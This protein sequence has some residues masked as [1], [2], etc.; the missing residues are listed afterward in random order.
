MANLFDQNM[1]PEIDA[2][3]QRIA[4]QQAIAEAM[5]TRSMAPL[6]TN[7]GP[8]HWTQALAQ[9]MN[10]RQGR[11][12]ID[13]A[14]RDRAGLGK[15]YQEG[16]ADEVKRIAALRQG[17]P[18]TETIVDEQANGGEGAPATITAPAVPNNRAAVEAAMLS[19]Y[20]P[21]RQMGM[22][23][24]SHLKKAD[25][26]YTLKPGE[27]RYGADGKLQNYEL[28]KESPEKSFK[29]GDIRK[30]LD[31]GSEVTQEFQKDGTW[32]E[33]SRGSRKE[34][35]SSVHV[36]APVT[37]VTVKDPNN[38]NNTIVV[39]GRTGRK[40]GDGPKLTDTG[41]AE[42]KRAFNMEGIGKTIQAAEDLLNGVKRNPDGT[43]G[44][45]QLPT[46]SGAGALIDAG[47]GFFGVS[48]RGSVQAKELEAVGGALTS[49]MPR[50]E[51]PQSDKDLAQYKQMAAEV[52]NRSIPI[53]ERKAALEKVKELWAK[54]ERLN[55][56][57][58][59]PGGDGW[60]VVR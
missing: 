6:P 58:F 55:P 28:P 34:G 37:P 26:P 23:E 29:Q 46:D 24:Y 17:K 48:P 36:A 2:E 56:E 60:S 42:F 51:G 7:Q 22:A 47:A 13:A 39:D 59:Q 30:F 40:I 57:A 5:L 35:G 11:V 16:L 10:A 31:G 49:K 20:G 9:V 54:Y 41:K 50:M 33:I 12:D 8:L 3:A 27:A 21:V 4:R 53:P 32:K 18:T 45:A 25:E 19:Q 15:K 38:P 14:A 43:T 1:P 44:K 52:G